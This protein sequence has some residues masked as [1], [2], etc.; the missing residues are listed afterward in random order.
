MK[1]LSKMAE[2][3]VGQ[4]MFLILEAAEKL[5]REGKHILHFELGE[6]DF[7]T[8]SNI[9]KS[10]NKALEEGFTHYA[11]SMGLHEFRQAIADVT[12]N[13][14]GF[15]PDLNQILVTPGANAII[16]LTIASVVNSGEEVIVPDPGFPTYFSALDMCGAK[17]VSVPLKE[18]NE[19]QLSP[20][21]LME[22]ITE[23]TKLIIV[24]SP[25]N[26]TGSCMTP[27]QISEVAKIAEEKNL[28][29]LSDEIY[30]RLIFENFEFSSPGSYDLCKERTIILNGFSKAFAMTGW[31]LGVA[32]GPVKLMEKM[33]LM[34]N[35]I[36]SCVPPFIQIAG[37]EALKG[38]QSELL[39]MKEEY[40]E[41]MKVLVEGL[42]T[43]ST[44][45]C[46]SPKGAMYV[47]PNISKTG[48]SSEEFASIC[49]NE[50]GVALLPG[51][52]FGSFGEGF[53]RM[54]YVNSKEKIE[55]ALERMRKIFK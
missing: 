15:R 54:C 49:L 20:K 5:E 2:R 40:Y 39:K 33:N 18:E 3:S 19:F 28:Y 1:S 13:S 36:V 6:P 9:I 16:Y 41:R 12:E 31:R 26:P 14:R 45:S 10:A 34:L 32:I 55:E 53:A 44:I 35:T 27:E 21:D 52:S 38:D 51:T 50:A 24:N 48:L 8:P 43:F 11:S 23:K 25:S 22:A 47:F 17:T 7:D 46:V 30:S 29:L 37:I 4:P 42:N